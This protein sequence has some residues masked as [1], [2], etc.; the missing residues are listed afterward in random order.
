MLPLPSDSPRPPP[1]LPQNISF[2]SKLTK[3]ET[4][5]YKRLKDRKEEKAA[6]K[7]DKAA[8]AANGTSGAES[9]S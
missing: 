5:F 3:L 8:A 7:R 1:L 4:K 9:S 6:K 2:A